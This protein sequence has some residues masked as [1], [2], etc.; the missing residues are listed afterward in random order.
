MRRGSHDTKNGEKV[1]SRYIK[2]DG[3][4]GALERG[5]PIISESCIVVD[6]TNKERNLKRGFEK[7]R[8]EP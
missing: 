1:P 4:V 3:I 7:E 8:V 2:P 5:R 6:G